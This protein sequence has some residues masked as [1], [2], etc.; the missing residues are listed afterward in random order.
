MSFIKSQS[1]FKGAIINGVSRILGSGLSFLLLLLI[2]KKFGAGIEVDSYMVALGFPILFLMVGE[3]LVT[4]SF[5]PIFIDYIEKENLDN[6]LEFSNSFFTVTTVCLGLICSIIYLFAPQIAWLQAPGFSAS[7]NFLTA[8]LIRLMSPLIFLGGIN[9]IL[10]SL[11]YSQRN[12]SVPAVCSLSS[13]VCSFVSLLV[14]GKT[15]GIASIPLGMSVGVGIQTMVEYFILQ[16]YSVQP[17]FSRNFSHTNMKRVIKLAGPRFMAMAANRF[18]IMTDRFFAAEL[19]SGSVSALSY[20]ER[21]IQFPFTIFLAAVGRTIT[22][23]LANHVSRG[24]LEE[25]KRILS[26]WMRMISFICIP[27]MMFLFIIHQP[28]IKLAFQRGAFNAYNTKL[29]A[30]AYFYYNIGFLSFCYNILFQITFFCLHDTFTPMKIGLWAV[31][32]NAGLDFVFVKSMGLAGIALVTSLVAIWR[33]WL[34][35]KYLRNKIGA[36]G[37]LNIF[38]SGLRHGSIAGVMGVICWFV[39]D[40]SREYFLYSNTL[41][42]ILFIGGITLVACTIY[43]LL[44]NLLK[45]EEYKEV[46]QYL[47]LRRNVS[48]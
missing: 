5:L 12:F 10:S 13:V 1:M 22:P 48:Q 17:R 47:V 45:V 4:V 37:G 2:S 46:S 23:T 33:T 36:F 16:K 21:L 25:V 7:T 11:F 28:V 44:C 41:N 26:N 24:E 6:A 20:A 9:G 19:V 32:L 39:M 31:A 18:N 34:L 3:N 8:R 42:Q 38:K 35:F 27:L 30:T 14:L 15:M 43:L 29:T 40:R